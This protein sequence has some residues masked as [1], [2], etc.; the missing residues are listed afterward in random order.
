MVW[1]WIN[2]QGIPDCYVAFFGHD[3]PA[4]DGK[5]DKP[6]VLRYYA[7]SLGPAS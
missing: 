4:P 2:E 5:P 6:Y 7:T 3:W 1:S